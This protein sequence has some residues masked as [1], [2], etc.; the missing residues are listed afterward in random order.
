MKCVE[1]KNR[2][3]DMLKWVGCFFCA[4]GNQTRPAHPVKQILPKENYF[5]RIK[6]YPKKSKIKYLCYNRSEEFGRK[7]EKC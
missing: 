2:K 1:V 6:F 3:S 7:E 5:L 4:G